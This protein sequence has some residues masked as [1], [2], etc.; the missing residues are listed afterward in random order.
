MNHHTQMLY[1]GSHSLAGESPLGQAPARVQEL[2][3]RLGVSVTQHQGAQRP[4]GVS[5]WTKVRQRGC[6][7]SCAARYTAHT[8]SP[9]P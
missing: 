8:I 3:V 6:R 9:G 1:Q 2:F 4:Q 7:L 5:D